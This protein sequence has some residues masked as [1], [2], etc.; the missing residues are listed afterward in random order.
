MASVFLSPHPDDA[1]LSCG[2]LIASLRDRGEA[3]TIVTVFSGAGGSNRLTPY[4]RL[5]LGFGDAAADGDAAAASATEPTPGEVSALRRVEDQAY[6][7]FVGAAIVFID[8]PDAVFRG[9]EGDTPLM[10]AP[11]PDDP[12]P[13][14]ALRR[15]LANLRP[16]DL[17]VPL[18]IGGHVDHRQVRRAAVALLSERDSPYRDRARFYEDFPYA[19]NTGFERLDQLDP[20]IRAGLPAGSKLEPEY[21]EIGGVIDRKLDGLRFY[22]SQLGRLFGEG[23]DPT[24]SAV[25]VR[26]ARVGELG[27]P[28]GTGVAG[29]AER[30]WRLTVD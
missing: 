27:R 22:E 11:R 12:P 5:A 1:A 14:D 21:V 28:G 2:G 8:L 15:T 9:Y 20:E 10:S 7:R 30:Y 29:A 23:D 3:V 16:A 19:L 17:Y 26:A 18:S 25:R 13:V 4:Q 24:S 6:A